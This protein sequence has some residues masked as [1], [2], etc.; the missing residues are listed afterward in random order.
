MQTELATTLDRCGSMRCRT[1]QPRERGFTLIELLVATTI[2]SILAAI[3]IP[4]YNNYVLRGQLPNATNGL[5]AAA[6]QM[7]Q[8]FQDYRSYAQV[9]TSP[10]PPCLTPS[11]SGQFTIEC[12]VPPGAPPA[13]PAAGA[14]VTASTYVIVAVGSGSTAGFYYTLDN[15]GNQW[16]QTGATWGTQTCASSWI[17]RQGTC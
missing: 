15:F 7:E 16:S 11:V 2:L 13:S 14:G 1:R 6:A 10:N 3:A 9:G 5:S 12:V 8:F 4:A 17:M